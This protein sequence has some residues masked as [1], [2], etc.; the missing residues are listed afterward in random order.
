MTGL[1]PIKIRLRTRPTGHLV[2]N[3]HTDL[4][5]ENNVNLNHDFLHLNDFEA[6]HQWV[7]ANWAKAVYVGDSH[8]VIF[9][10][11]GVSTEFD[12]AEIVN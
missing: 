9:K 6:N 10:Q 12:C 8:I 3:D 11:I 2:L 7:T 4:L 5:M 1:D